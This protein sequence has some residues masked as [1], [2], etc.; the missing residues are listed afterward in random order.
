MLAA[1]ALWTR[2]V[3]FWCN[4]EWNESELLVPAL[5]IGVN[6]HIRRNVSRLL[7]LSAAPGRLRMLS[8]L[9]DIPGFETHFI[10]SF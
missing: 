2:V 8:W 1:G 9:R 10:A 6:M 5:V 4:Y 3:L 7:G